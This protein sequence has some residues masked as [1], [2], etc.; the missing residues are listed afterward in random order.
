MKIYEYDGKIY[1]DEDIS[2]KCSMYEGDMYD[3][4]LAMVR[5]GDLH[6][7][8]TYWSPELA[9]GYEDEEEAVDEMISF[10]YGESRTL[11]EVTDVDEEE[12]DEEEE[13]EDD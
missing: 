8:V 4:L 12:E 2:E 7:N 6:E 5:N 3:L 11:E 9:E 1:A 10:G 13:E